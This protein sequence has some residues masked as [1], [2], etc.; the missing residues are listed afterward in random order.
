MAQHIANKRR[1]NGT[2]AKVRDDDRMEEDLPLLPLTP[3]FEE[4]PTGPGLTWR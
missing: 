1:P 2:T 3:F 4:L